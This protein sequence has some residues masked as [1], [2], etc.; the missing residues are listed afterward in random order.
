[1]SF[2]QFAL[3]AVVAVGL[4][5]FGLWMLGPLLNA[6]GSLEGEDL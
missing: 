4:G 2:I 3:A 1:M 5:A 6:V